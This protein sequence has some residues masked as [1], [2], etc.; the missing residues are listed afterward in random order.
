MQAKINT[1]LEVVIARNYPLSR[2]R[3]TIRTEVKFGTPSTDCR[4]LGICKVVPKASWSHPDLSCRTCRRA[5]AF[6]TLADGRLEIRF[7]RRTMCAYTWGK[8]FGQQL[9]IVE[10]DF[11]LSTAITEQFRLPTGS[12]IPAGIYPVQECGELACIYIGA[13]APR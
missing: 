8:Y 3:N 10:E 7:I 6:F 2:R 5:L 13:L 1:E 4:G 9:F 12:R 11:E